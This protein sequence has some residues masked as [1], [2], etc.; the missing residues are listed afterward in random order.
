M[1]VADV[2][3]ASGEPFAP[4]QGGGLLRLRELVLGFRSGSV[5]AACA[6]ELD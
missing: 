6:S 5:G 3:P 4:R 2:G 1:G